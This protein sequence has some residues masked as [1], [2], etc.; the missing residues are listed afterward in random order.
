MMD[1]IVS[2][3]IPRFLLI[4]YIVKVF[5]KRFGEFPYY[6]VSMTL[7]GALIVYFEIKAAK[8]KKWDVAFMIGVF[9]LILIGSIFAIGME[10]SQ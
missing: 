5:I 10:V 6:T 8:S 7:S 2:N 3:V 4:K 9:A 1:M